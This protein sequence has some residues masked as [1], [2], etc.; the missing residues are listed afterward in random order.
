MSFFFVRAREADMSTMYSVGV[1]AY[2]LKAA[3][4]SRG[5]ALLVQCSKSER[6][7]GHAKATDDP[8]MCDYASMWGTE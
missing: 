3:E 2:K 4:A 7:A 5:V 6:H 8:G 1:S